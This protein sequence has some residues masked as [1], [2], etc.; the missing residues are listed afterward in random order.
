MRSLSTIRLIALISVW[1]VLLAVTPCG[2]TIRFLLPEVVVAATPSAA[3]SGYFEV[4]LA[5]DPGDFPQEVSSQNV[6]VLSTDARLT[7]GLPIAATTPLLTG[8]PL[9][10]SPNATTLRAALD[11]FP[12]AQPLVDGAGLVRIPYSVSPGAT[13]EFPLVFGSLNQLADANAL[14]IPINATDVGRIRVRMAGDYNADGIVNLA[15]YTVWRDNLGAPDDTPLGGNGT[16]G[17]VGQADYA[18]WKA[19]F[20]AS[21]A[22][23]SAS[24]AVP[25]PATQAA[26]LLLVAV[27]A[28]RGGRSVAVWSRPRRE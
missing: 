5:A 20:G 12:N 14:S 16:G 27:L 8:D 13:G 22:S 26:V 24:A 21:A 11:N 25:E 4:T 9:D 10:F 19:N 28:M 3:T 1:Q 6:E 15:D 2:A 17:T 18:L 7:F 23:A